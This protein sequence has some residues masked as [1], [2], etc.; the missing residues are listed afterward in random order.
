MTTVDGELSLGMVGRVL[1]RRKRLIIGS[2]LMVTALAFVGVNLIT[3]RYK[4]EARLLVEGREN[5][6]LRPE[7]DKALMD[8]TTVD[9]ETVTSQVQLVLSRDLAR[10]VIEQLKLAEQP[11]F[12]AALQGFSP[13]SG[14][15][16]IGLLKD[17]MS[18]T[19]EER[20]LTA[21]YERL[22]AYAA[23]RGAA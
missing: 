21:Y 23:E 2:V 15:Q 5:I 1:W 22:N 19:L 4:S 10:E 14:L 3:P 13:L 17:P 9:P 8:R 20:V 12:N 18:L 11:E 6:F 16:T 7:A